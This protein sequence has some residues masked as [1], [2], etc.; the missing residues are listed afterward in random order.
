MTYEELTVMTEEERRNALDAEANRINDLEAE[1]DS[2]KNENDKLLSE[3]KKLEEELKKTKELNFT[4]G[5]KV[6][7]ATT[8]SAEELLNE[9]FK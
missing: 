6:N 5:R 8:K 3:N 4:L 7:T 9:L 2:F 1:R